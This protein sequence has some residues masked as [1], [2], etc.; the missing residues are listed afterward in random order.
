MKKACPGMRPGTSP[1]APWPIRT[2]RSCRKPWKN[3]PSP[4]SRNCC[5]AFTSSSKKSTTAGSKKSAASIPAMNRGPA[6]SPS[7]GM[8]RSTWPIW[9]S[10][11]ATASTVSP[12]SI[13]RSSRIR[14]CT[15]SIR[16]SRTASPIRPTA[17]PIAA[18]SSKP[19]RSWPR[20]STK[21]SGT[22]GAG[23]RRSSRTSCLLPMT[24][25]SRNS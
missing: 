16:A 25:P 14:R 19:I 11:A 17:F 5:R 8:D 2:T 21:P 4:C 12:K 20:S 3:G 15:S 9:P 23:R 10:S 1:S 22:A 24:R 18:G 13:R 6:T 7:S